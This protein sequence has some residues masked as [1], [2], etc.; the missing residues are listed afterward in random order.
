MVS[1]EFPLTRPIQYKEILRR[2][3]AH[4][5]P[6]NVAG[7]ARF[8]INPNKTYG[9]S[10]PY[11]RALAKE[12]GTDHRLAGQLWASGYHEARILASL[13]DGPEFV[14]AAQMEQ[15]ARDFDSWDVCDQCCMNLL[16]RTKFAY[17]KAAQWSKR[18]GEFIKR[19][20]FVLIATCAVHDQDTPDGVFV[21][22][23]AAVKRESTDE[24]NF[25][26]K[27]VNWALRQIGK[28]NAYL[29]ARAIATAQEIRSLDSR[30]A[31][32]IAEDALR[33]LTSAAVRKKLR[34]HD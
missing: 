8:G 28:R 27:A 17:R 23:L 11:L 12:I 25:V 22:F 1:Y 4:S 21:Q 29:N 15:W 5:N 13:V 7:M 3:E 20:G 34:A 30:T 16:R 2:L 6:K 14:T 10:M 9:I 26:R 19:A 24:R 32:W 31:R 18:E 33:E